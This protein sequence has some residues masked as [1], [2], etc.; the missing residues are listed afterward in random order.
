MF[1]PKIL[2]RAK[3]IFARKPNIMCFARRLFAIA[4]QFVVARAD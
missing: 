4:R 1:S 3:K 2:L